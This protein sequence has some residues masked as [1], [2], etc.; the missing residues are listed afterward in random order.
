MKKQSYKILSNK[1]CVNPEC[2]RRLKQNVV[3]RNP[4]VEHC[5]NCYPNS[6][7]NR[8]GAN[9]KMYVPVFHNPTII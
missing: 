9:R 5:Y 8:A 3:D 7:K 1:K 4:D 6:K 2:R